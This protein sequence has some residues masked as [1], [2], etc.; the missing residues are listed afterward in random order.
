MGEIMITKTVNQL[1]EEKASIM[2][3]YPIIIDGDETVTYGNL[4]GMINKVSNSL[5][6]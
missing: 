5:L 2:R 4:Y 6:Y 3:D 1:I